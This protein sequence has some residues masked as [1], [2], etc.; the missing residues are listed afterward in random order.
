MGRTHAKCIAAH[1]IRTDGQIA[2]LQ[3]LDAVDVESL[4]DHAAVLGDRAAF[5]RRHAAGSQRVP[6]GFDVALDLSTL[7]GFIGSGTEKEEKDGQ[8]ETAYSISQSP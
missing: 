5:A 1:V 6:G 8:G 7:V 3:A 4:V 2:D